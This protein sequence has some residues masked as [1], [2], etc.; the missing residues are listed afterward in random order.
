MH[1]HSKSRTHSSSTQSLLWRNT[2]RSRLS[3]LYC[4]CFLWLSLMHFLFITFF[5]L[6]LAEGIFLNG[7]LAPSLLV[8]FSNLILSGYTFYSKY[9]FSYIPQAFIWVH[10]Q[11]F[12]PKC[13]SLSWLFPL[14]GII[15]AGYWHIQLSSL[16]KSLSQRQPW[17]WRSFGQHKMSGSNGCHFGAEN[18]NSHILSPPLQQLILCQVAEAQSAWVSEWGKWETELPAD[19]H[20]KC[21]INGK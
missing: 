7:C 19:L 9:C 20:W 1:F 3:S 8:S 4:V 2:I 13:S 6:F 11:L 5:P 16:V 17:R 18:F 14:C 10:F 15:S 12:R 21:T